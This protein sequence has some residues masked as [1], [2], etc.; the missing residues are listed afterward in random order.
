MKCGGKNIKNKENKNLYKERKYY[1]SD[2]TEERRDKMLDIII[3]V[4]FIIASALGIGSFFGT[5]T[6]NNLIALICGIIGLVAIIGV[7]CYYNWKYKKS[8]LNI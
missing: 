5:I 4:V 2:I 7:G 1:N 3:K 6:Q 8:L